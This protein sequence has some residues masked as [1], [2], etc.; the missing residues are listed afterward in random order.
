MSKAQPLVAI[1]LF[2]STPQ[3]KCEI[4]RVAFHGYV[5]LLSKGTQNKF[6]D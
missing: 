3:A 1:S 4:E 5:L 6:T 2:L